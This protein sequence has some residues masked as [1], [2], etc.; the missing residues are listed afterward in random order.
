MSRDKGVALRFGADFTNLKQKS[1]NAG[2][3]W[4]DEIWKQRVLGE[5]NFDYD[6]IIGPIADRDV[7]SYSA[8]ARL[9]KVSKDKYFTHIAPNMGAKQ[10]VIKTAKAVEMIVFDG[11]ERVL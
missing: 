9:G 1:F 5:D 10:Y 11:E 2:V 6:I 3:L 8:L 7:Q 4:C